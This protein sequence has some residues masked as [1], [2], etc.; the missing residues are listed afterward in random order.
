M[1]LSYES[2]LFVKL[3][4]P[5]VSVSVYHIS[6]PYH[7]LKRSAHTSYVLSHIGPDIHQ[8][9]HFANTQKSP[10]GFSSRTKLIGSGTWIR[11]TISGVKVRCP[12]IRRSP[13][14]LRFRLR[15]TTADRPVVSSLRSAIIRS[16]PEEDEE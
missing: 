2:F 14:S 1:K 10:S 4:E 13:I 6:N 3:C 16:P 5:Y 9:N 11:T 15:R 8:D 7:N 12:T